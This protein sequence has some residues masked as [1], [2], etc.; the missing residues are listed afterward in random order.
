MRI[1]SGFVYYLLSLTIIA[2]VLLSFLY[3]KRLRHLVFRLLDHLKLTE[4][5]IFKMIFWIAFIVV[6]LFLIDSVMKYMAVKEALGSTPF[7]I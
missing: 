5:S 2:T 6:A 3:F 7:C 1:T 4:T